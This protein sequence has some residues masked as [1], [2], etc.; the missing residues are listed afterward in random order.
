M[1]AEPEPLPPDFDQVANRLARVQRMRRKWA[2]RIGATC[3]R[4]YEKDLPDQPLIADWYDG[5]VVVWA[6][7]RTRND[8]PEQESAWLDG[9]HAA[10]RRG[11]D[12]PEDRLW[13]KRRAR[14][15]GRHAGAGQYDRLDQRA[16]LKTVREGTLLFEVNLSDYLDTGLFLDHR[17][18]R[19]RVGAEAAGK[20]VLNLF[21]YTGAFTVH[22]RAGGAAATTTVDLSKTYLAWAERNLALNGFAADPQHELVRADCLAW[23]AAAAAAGPRWD[24]IVCDPPTFSSS[25]AMRHDFSIERDQGRLLTWLW[26]LVRPGGTVWF[27]TNCRGF[28]L[29]LSALPKVAVEETSAWTVPEDFRNR[30]IHQSWRLMKPLQSI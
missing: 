6:L 1:T 10:V 9:I 26:T 18:L 8:T 7:D 29:D 21:A 24:V 15:H 20:R 11:L 16:A 30:K 12:L 22:A 25:T 4:I 27:S 17:P 14:Q 5:D 19:A 3:W 2:K 23:L 28:R 13:L